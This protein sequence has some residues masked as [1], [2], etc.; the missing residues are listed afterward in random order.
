MQRVT[1]VS[2]VV[3]GAGLALT[4]IVYPALSTDGT[5]HKMFFPAVIQGPTATPTANQAIP[6]ST[7][8][9]CQQPT[10]TPLPPDPTGTCVP[11]PPPGT[12]TP[13]PW[14]TRPLCNPTQTPGPPRPCE[15]IYPELP[16]CTPPIAA[17]PD[18]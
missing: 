1:L 14:L 7:P 11:E 6:T 9:S 4:A 13:G 3:L 8:P 18:P 12:Y 17:T 10:C 5:L 15:R 16:T 2:L